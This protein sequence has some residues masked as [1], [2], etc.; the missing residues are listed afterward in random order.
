M[1]RM[2][3]YLTRPQANW[4]VR[5]HSYFFKCLKLLRRRCLTQRIAA[6]GISAWNP[7]STAHFG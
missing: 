1:L 7:G 2:R 4:G 3:F 6:L 5:R